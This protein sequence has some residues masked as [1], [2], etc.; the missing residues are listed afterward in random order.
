MAY[1][2]KFIILILFSF[3]AQSFERLEYPD[4]F[5]MPGEER[6]LKISNESGRT[7]DDSLVW[8][9]E[10]FNY[11]L[12]REVSQE[13]GTNRDAFEVALAL[14]PSMLSTYLH[15]W[16][17]ANPLFEITE[18]TDEGALWFFREDTQQ[19]CY[20]QV[21]ET[22]LSYQIAISGESCRDQKIEFLYKPV[23]KVEIDSDFFSDSIHYFM[24]EQVD[25][26]PSFDTSM[27]I[28]D[29]G[30]YRYNPKVNSKLEPVSCL[31]DQCFERAGV[32]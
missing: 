23:Y 30:T 19:V 4:L 25:R 21:V 3:Q 16:F 15:Q 9:A 11:L 29:E 32:Q 6:V 20:A 10:H 7:L 12:M 14:D 5:F 13:S 26:Y 24:N 8:Q 2:A 1:F 27:F 17:R 22:K 31:P 18:L 28:E